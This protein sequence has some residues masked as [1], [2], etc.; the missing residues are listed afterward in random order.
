MGDNGLQLVNWA[1]HKREARAGSSRRE[2]GFLSGVSGSEDEAKTQARKRSSGEFSQDEGQMKTEIGVERRTSN[3]WNRSRVLS[4]GGAASSRAGDPRWGGQKWAAPETASQQGLAHPSS[5]HRCIPYGTTTPSF[6]TPRPR[7]ARRPAHVQSIFLLGRCLAL[8]FP[9][10]F[11]YLPAHPI[12]TGTFQHRSRGPAPSPDHTTHYG[13]RAA[14]S[15]FDTVE[16]IYG[17]G[18]LPFRESPYRGQ[19]TPASVEMSMGYMGAPILRTGGLGY[20]T[21][22]P[23]TQPFSR[24]RED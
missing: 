15:P 4:P 8:E 5:P 18:W 21:L 7:Q 22:E 20:Q 10:G 14:M 23:S 1:D 24:T 12:R 17:Q 16:E 19:N 3:N 13:S 6:H 2:S 9:L 11:S